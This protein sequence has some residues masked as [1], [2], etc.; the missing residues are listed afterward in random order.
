M[1]RRITTVAGALVMAVG[2]CSCTMTEIPE[3]EVVHNTEVPPKML[4]L[5]EYIEGAL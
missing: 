4:F 2:L 1:L 3:R 5:C